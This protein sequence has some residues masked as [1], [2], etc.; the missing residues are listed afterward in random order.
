MCI[1]KCV[2]SNVYKI[3]IKYLN[4]YYYIMINPYTLSRNKDR[5]EILKIRNYK[6]VLNLCHRHI[7][8]KS[9]DGFSETIY[10]VPRFVFGLPLYDYTM[11]KEYIYNRLV[12]NKLKCEFINDQYLK[13]SW[14]HIENNRKK[15][16][17]FEEIINK[18][19]STS[20]LIKDKEDKKDQKEVLKKQYRQPDDLNNLTIRL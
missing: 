17:E 3:K 11:C 7:T 8:K 18:T 4:I 13:I 2:Y 20:F 9:N 5:K 15:E 16:Q 1:F 10:L 12:Q 19:S 14:D 6:Q